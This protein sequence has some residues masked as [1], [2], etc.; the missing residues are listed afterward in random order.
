MLGSMA[1]FHTVD[2]LTSL[3]KSEDQVCYFCLRINDLEVH[4][5]VC[6]IIVFY[7]LSGIIG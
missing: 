1:S 4:Y 5:S 2:S 3:V 7:N 6:T